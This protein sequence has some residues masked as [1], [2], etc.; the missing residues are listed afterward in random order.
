M[1][2]LRNVEAM[3]LTQARIGEVGT[4]EVVVLDDI[5]YFIH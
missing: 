1:T 5:E 3:V 4:F 2:R